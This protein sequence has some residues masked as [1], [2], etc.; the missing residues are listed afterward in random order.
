MTTRISLL[1]LLCNAFAISESFCQKMV[2]NFF[3]EG[4]YRG[5]FRSGVEVD[6][7]CK[8]NIEE[9]SVK[10]YRLD[11]HLDFDI[12]LLDFDDVNHAN[13]VITQ[14]DKNKNVTKHDWE[15]ARRKKENGD[16]EYKNCTNIF[17]YEEG[18]LVGW[19]SLFSDSIEMKTSLKYNFDDQ[20]FGKESGGNCAIFHYL[21]VLFI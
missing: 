1:F 13:Y 2:D 20:W 8:G 5:C 11:S 6:S 12:S 16:Y 18:L 7:E 15:S 21:F 19:S 3:L 17:N 10:A 14:Y 4:G 9:V